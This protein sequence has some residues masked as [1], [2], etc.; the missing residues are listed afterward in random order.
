MGRDKGDSLSER[1]QA[2]GF[3]V[4]DLG[5]AMEG[6]RTLQVEVVG[7]SVR[8]PRESGD[9]FLCTL[10]VLDADGAPWIAFHSATSL[11]ETLAGL[12]ARL[13]NGTLK[14][15]EDTWARGRSSTPSPAAPDGPRGQ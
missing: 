14:Y 7:F 15:R 10:R 5:L 3:A 13:W 9:E 4:S 2:T 12:V 11:D 6:K 1:M 8:A